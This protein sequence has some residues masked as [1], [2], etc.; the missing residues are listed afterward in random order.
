MKQLNFFEAQSGPCEHSLEKKIV[1]W[2]LSVDGASRNNPGP[3]G[4]GIYITKSGSP[5]IG[6]GFFLGVKTNNQ[7]EYLALLL[8]IFFV[9]QLMQSHDTLEIIS[10]SLLLIRQV[11]G[12]YRV[13]DAQLQLLHGVAKTM[14]RHC[15]YKVRHVLREY[16]VEADALANKGID[17]KIGV[18]DAFRKMLSDHHII[19]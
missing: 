17:E 2:T 3:S 16:N 4:A 15:S 5:E 8:G 6:K 12:V 10:D 19:L 11:E 14:L 7:A 1:H 18:P 9:R 13:K